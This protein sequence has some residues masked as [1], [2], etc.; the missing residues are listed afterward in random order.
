MATVKRHD[1]IKEVRGFT[2]GELTGKIQMSK[3]RLLELEQEKLLGK[4]KD[5]S[6]IPQLR[7]QIA[8]LMTIRDEKVSNEV[9]NA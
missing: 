3:K 5:V 9:S 8:Q 7:K 1:F 4:L 2:V 6:E